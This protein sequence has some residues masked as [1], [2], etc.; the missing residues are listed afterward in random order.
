MYLYRYTESQIRI[1]IERVLVE[2]LFALPKSQKVTFF[3]FYHINI[4]T[5]K[6]GA[7][8]TGKETLFGML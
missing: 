3:C 5:Q 1:H 8:K 6:Y 2:L 4:S 7:K